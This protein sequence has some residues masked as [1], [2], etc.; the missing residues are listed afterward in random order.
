MKSLRFTLAAFLCLQ[1][2]AFSTIDVFLN[3]GATFESSLDSMTTDAGVTNFSASEKAA[4]R[5]NIQTQLQS[6][7]S[8]FTIN[9]LTTDPGTPRHTVNFNAT[10]ANNNLF[11]SAPGDAHNAFDDQTA[12][13]FTRNFHNAAGSLQ[14]IE[15]GDAR[16]QII[17]EVSTALAGTAA[18]EF[19]HSLGLH[20]HHA[21][22]AAG[23]NPS[24][25]ANT[26]GLQN[27]NIMA[28]GS[29]GLTETG[30]DSTDRT[31]SDFSKLH[32]ETAGALAPWEEVQVRPWR[33]RSHFSRNWARM[34]VAPRHPRPWRVSSCPRCWPPIT[35]PGSSSPPWQVMPT[36]TCS[37]S[38]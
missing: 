19:G 2:T 7:Y 21:Y 6:I 31:L 9:F 37:A 10:T 13:V 15:A 25:Y 17:D 14:V 24:T 18:H 32:I 22:D 11:G 1:S 5:S 34:S 35:L 16:A 36:S 38:P 33:L 12:S 26:G 28:T 23:I 4:I 29:T 20:H 3:F 27:Q 8:D 30:R